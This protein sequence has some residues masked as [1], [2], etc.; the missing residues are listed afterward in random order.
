MLHFLGSL[1]GRKG[2]SKS[3][4]KHLTRSQPSSSQEQDVLGSPGMD[5]QGGHGRKE[6]QARVH[7]AA[8]SSG[9]REP[10]PRVL[11][12]A[13][14]NPR[15]DAF[16][17]GTGDSGSQTLTSNDVLKLRV[18]EV[19][20]TSVPTRGAWEVLEYLPEKKEEEEPAGEVSGASDR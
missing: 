12:A 18:Q 3:A 17:Q 7:S 10:Q 20:G 6:P 13:S 5:H 8:S 11:S 1:V 15:H 4:N 19:E 16:G 14:S 2:S 9:K